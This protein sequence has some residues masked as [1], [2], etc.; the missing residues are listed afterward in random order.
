MER[1]GNSGWEIVD[2]VCRF[3]NGGRLLRRGAMSPTGVVYRCAN[4]GRTGYDP[5]DLCWCGQH[6]KGK[7]TQQHYM[8]LPYVFTEEHPEFREVILDLFRKCGC[9]PENGEVG[10]VT[11]E[12]FRR[13]MKDID[14]HE[15][16]NRNDD[17]KTV[18]G[19]DDAV[20][21]VKKALEKTSDYPGFE[22]LPLKA[23]WTEMAG[24][25]E[26]SLFV[27]AVLCVLVELWKKEENSDC[28]RQK[29][30]DRV[31]KALEKAQNRK[32]LSRFFAG[33]GSVTV[34]GPK[35]VAYI[36][37]VSPDAEELKD[38]LRK[39]MARDEELASLLEEGKIEIVLE[40]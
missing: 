34:E 26:L 35:F 1:N 22:L 37:E 7:C 17:A 2:H 21:K 32:K 3:C 23:C 18:K 40:W 9:D 4:C 8:C 14:L 30:E 13:L 5:A 16:I 28:L 12:D 25:G 19:L 33:T 38:F 15:K 29:I 11:V 39:E 27:Y 24:R 6:F 36:D 20:A 10:I 31:R